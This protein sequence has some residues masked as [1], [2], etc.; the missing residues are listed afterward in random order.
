MDG[1]LDNEVMKIKSVAQIID[2]VDERYMML[3]EMDMLF[4][5]EDK[6]V[7]LNAGLDMGTPSI[8]FMLNIEDTAYPTFIPSGEPSFMPTG[9]TF[10][11]PSLPTLEPTSSSGGGVCSA[12]PNKLGNGVCNK[13]NG[14]NVAECNWD[15][16]DCCEASCLQNPTPWK[17]KRCGVN[18]YDCKDPSQTP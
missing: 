6:Y 1:E 12:E 8:V 15:D 10:A 7:T 14:N 3:M 11:Q 16:G 18:G 13:F 5:D 9:E 17:R 4:G 2:G